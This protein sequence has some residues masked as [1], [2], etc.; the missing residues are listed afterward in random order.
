MLKGLFVFHYAKTLLA[1][2]S[3]LYDLIFVLMLIT[4]SVI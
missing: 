1:P 2:Y 4:A 3:S